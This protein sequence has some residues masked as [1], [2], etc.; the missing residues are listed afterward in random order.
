MYHNDEYVFETFYALQLTP[1]SRLQPD[2]QIVW[3]PAFNP[4]SGPAVVFQF[5]FL[6]K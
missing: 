3:N 6:L 4:D 2:L 1:M 5:Q